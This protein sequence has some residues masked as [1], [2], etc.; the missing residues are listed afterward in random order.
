MAVFF[1]KS[2]RIFRQDFSA[3]FIIAMI[4]FHGAKIAKIDELE[5]EIIGRKEILHDLWNRSKKHHVPR[6]VLKGIF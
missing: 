6:A 5:T 1:Q 4:T 3:N 2:R